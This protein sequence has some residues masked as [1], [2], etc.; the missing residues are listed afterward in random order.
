MI[1]LQHRCKLCQTWHWTK[2]VSKLTLFVPGRSKASSLSD[3][4]I[5]PKHHSHPS[6]STNIQTILISIPLST[7]H[8]LGVKLDRSHDIHPKPNMGVCGC[9]AAQNHHDQFLLSTPRRVLGFPRHA[10][11]LVHKSRGRIFWYQCS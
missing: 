7:S 1:L 8:Q 6:A 4:F 2:D 9:I 10:P 5:M 11:V 3:V